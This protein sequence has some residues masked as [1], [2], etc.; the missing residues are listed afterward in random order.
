MPDQRAGL[1]ADILASLLPAASK[2]LA[3]DPPAATA[4]A[5]P[6]SPGQAIQDPLWDAADETRPPSPRIRARLR[7][8]RRENPNPSGGGML[9]LLSHG[10]RKG[11]RLSQNAPGAGRH[12]LEDPAA[13]A[14]LS[15]GLKQAERL[16][17]R[18]RRQV[19]AAVKKK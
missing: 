10:S 2:H 12:D 11:Q 7:Q 18:V 8:A 9:P 6:E 1:I 13:R 15:A 14:A 17:A 4:D 3:A 16:A 5:A 19:L